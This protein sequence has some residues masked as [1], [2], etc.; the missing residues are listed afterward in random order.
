MW[1][2]QH[3]DF[4]Y[5]GQWISSGG[6]GTMGFGLPAAIGAYYAQPSRQII[7]IDGDG[8]FQMNIQELAT[9]NR[10]MNIKV[11][12]FNNGCLGM[13][14]QWENR[15]YGG[16]NN[17]TCL[18]RSIDCDDMCRNGDGC[19]TFNPDFLALSHVYKQVNTLRVTSEEDLTKRILTALRSPGPYVVDVL[20]DRKA[21]VLPMVPP[22]KGF[23]D[24]LMK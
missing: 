8:S 2:A 19:Y 11:F 3:Y 20:I 12:I 23:A 24:L 15:F 16:Y 9:L 13:V 5:P 21:D 17:E 4:K 10:N 7:C 14:R 6:L 18:A 1:A 22:G